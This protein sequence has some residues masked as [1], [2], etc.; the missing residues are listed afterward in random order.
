MT[1]AVCITFGRVESIMQD[2]SPEALGNES[3]VS[4]AIIKAA[5]RRIRICFKTN[6]GPVLFEMLL[7]MQAEYEANVVQSLGCRCALFGTLS[8]S[9][10]AALNTDADGFQLNLAYMY[11]FFFQNNIIISAR[12]HTARALA[13]D[14]D[15]AIYRTSTDRTKFSYFLIK[16]SQN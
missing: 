4:A 6:P 10:S 11:S 7:S 12:A 15:L 9:R 8:W 5:R 3:Q 13:R 2:S 16:S 14:A 1:A